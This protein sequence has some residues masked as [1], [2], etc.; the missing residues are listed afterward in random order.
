MM[1]DRDTKT[2]SH[3]ILS[4]ALNSMQDIIIFSL[5]RNYQ[6]NSFNDAHKQEMAKVYGVEIAIGMNMLD[7]ITDPEVKIYAKTSFDRALAGEH[8][9]EVQRQPGTDIVY[10]FH[11]NPVRE[12][13]NVT[14]GFYVFI[15]NIT[16]RVKIEEQRARADAE[17]HSL[18]DRVALAKEEWEKTMDCVYEIVLLVDAEGRVKRCNMPFAQF[19]DKSYQDILD[20][21]WLEL[22]KEK[23]IIIKE[24]QDKRFEVRQ[25][26]TGNWFEVSLFPGTTGPV[27]N[28]TAITVRDITDLKKLTASLNDYSSRLKL[29]EDRLES[30]WKLS[31]M[32]EA[33]EAELFDHA[34]ETLV[35]LTRSTGGYLHFLEHGEES[36]HLYAWSR[37]VMKDCKA[38]KTAH[39]PIQQAGIW[40]DCVR[41]RRV[42]IHND[43]AS[44]PGK[45]GHPPGH[46][47]IRR[48]MSVPVFD[49]SVI[50]AVAGVGNKE[51]QYTDD[52]AKQVSLFMGSVWRVLK[53]KR[54]EKLMLQQEKM[55]SIGQLA[56]GIAHEINNPTGFIMSNLSVLNK[57]S[58]RLAEFIRLQGEAIAGMR[59]GTEA[60][61]IEILSRLEEKRSA[62]KIDRILSDLDSLIA[63][64]LD[65]AERIK[66]IVQDLKGF[67]RTNDSEHAAAD[68]N[69]G[70]ESTINI[71]WNEIKY[72]ATVRKEFG[73]L[74]QV[75][76]NQGQLNQV[77]MNMLVNAA[78]AIEN[79]GEIVVRTWAEN[80]RVKIAISDTGCG[81]SPDNM[82]HIFDP[83]F[84]TKPVGKG[85]GLG[86]SIAYDI[87]KKHN[88]TITVESAVNRGSTFTVQL[89]IGEA[90]PQAG[91]KS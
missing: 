50:V 61:S 3:A 25:E 21:N 89:P 30:L 33:S 18:F 45:K 62:I 46:F 81:I 91:I 8:F 2:A 14:S 68:I 23:G 70:L 51:Q 34:L 47:A 82:K 15:L 41:R 38:E 12:A 83:F 63:E 55:A 78:H 26:K 28:Y 71:V 72:K 66:K 84:T 80:D 75:V 27:L 36:F 69:A 29:D 13:N 52:D 53:Q 77:F 57:Y 16:A 87:V 44:E 39:Y 88:G 76:C 20:R 56:A 42:V 5:D 11:W 32:D 60:K 31:E 7:C 64:S 43:Y 24:A 79:K 58:E 1:N 54:Q 86:L 10:E 49:G 37:D 85:T 4:S 6:Y 22:I 19:L 74:P 35:K 73:D 59:T 67:S 40:A 48:H 90:R 65:G 9:T 17:L